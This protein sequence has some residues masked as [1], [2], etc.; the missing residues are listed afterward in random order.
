[1]ITKDHLQILQHSLG[2]D[3]YGQGAQ[4]RNHFCP[5]GNDVMR[6]EELESLGLMWRRTVFD[7]VCFHVSLKGKKFVSV[8][9]PKPPKLSKS[10]LRYLQWMDV[11]DLYD[12]GFGEWLK[13]GLY[14]EA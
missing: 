8:H 7:D 5:G 11:A 4:Y 10:K 12:F 1:M 14:K 3:Q 13:R 6:C 9:S 2:V